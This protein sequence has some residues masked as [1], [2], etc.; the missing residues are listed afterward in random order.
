MPFRTLPGD[1]DGV[2]DPSRYND[3]LV[4]V[5]KGTMSE[6][7]LHVLK[8]R[9]NEG[10]RA[11]AGRGELWFRLPMGY[12]HQPS[13][14]IVK[15]PDEQAQ[16]VMAMIFGV[17]ERCR[18]IQGVLHHL[19]RHQVRLPCRAE[20]GPR[21]G[22]LEWRSPNRSTLST[23]LHHPIYT[24]AYV[25]GRRPVDPRRKKPGRAGT[26]RTVATRAQWE[27]LLKDQFAGYI[28]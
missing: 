19:V 8:Q 24:G 5:M 18:T 3:W 20:S 28:T 21:K 4:L 9:M 16:A 14:E 2:C 1:L 11:K 7:E 6:A 25:Y 12:V 17:F 22:E 10:R 15:D 13:G 23:V 26:G 27:V